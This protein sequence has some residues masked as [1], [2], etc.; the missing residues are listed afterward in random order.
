MHIVFTGQV[1]YV[2]SEAHHLLFGGCQVN[3]KRPITGKRPRPQFGQFQI[4][5]AART[6]LPSTPTMTR[7]PSDMQD[8]SNNISRTRSGLS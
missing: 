8:G 7:K 6:G 4:I 3:L 5:L 2:G 1:A